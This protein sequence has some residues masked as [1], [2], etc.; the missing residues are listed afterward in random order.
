MKPFSLFKT[1]A[2][3]LSVVALAALLTPLGALATG[4]RVSPSVFVSVENEIFAADQQPFI[5][6][7]GVEAG[8]VTDIAS[9]VL[10]A[11]EVDALITTL[12]L[13]SMVKYHLTQ[14]QAIAALGS[15]F[16]F[17]PA[18]RDAL[19]FVPLFVSPTYHLYYRPAHDKVLS[20]DGE[21]KSLSGLRYGA[22]KGEDAS[23]YEKAGVK[24]VF[25]SE[26]S[27]LKKLKSG[28]V[29]FIRLTPLAEAWLLD[30]HHPDDKT[31]FARMPHPAGSRSF[32]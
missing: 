14:E 22:L 12:P 7:A 16:T 19:V 2:A 17:S 4:P 13:R 3:A 28:D 31:D 27:L 26:R 25:G 18:E 15:R 11:A 21:L 9:A 6:T 23:A 8:L 29:D 5:S 1:C 20:W 30:R 10:K 32:L 24:V